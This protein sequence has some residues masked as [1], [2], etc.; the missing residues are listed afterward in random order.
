MKGYWLVLASE[1][2]DPEARAEYSK[3]WAPLAEKYQARINKNDVPP[4]L[5][6]GRNT[7]RVLVIEFPSLEMAKAC[8]DD[9]DYQEALK[10]AQQSATRD[11]LILEG[12]IA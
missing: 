1:V 7:A 8:Y 11:L 2:T 3:R 6:E 10:Y 9:P 5:K 4:L 12:D